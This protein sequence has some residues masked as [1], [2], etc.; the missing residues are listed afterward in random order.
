M[1]RGKIYCQLEVALLWNID[2]QAWLYIKISRK[3]RNKDPNA[4]AAP[5]TIR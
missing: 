4:Q 3:I 1:M 5:Q 2:S